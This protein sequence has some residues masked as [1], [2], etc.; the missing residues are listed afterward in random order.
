MVE[1]F[2]LLSYDQGFESSHREGENVKKVTD[3][4]CLKFWLL[5]QVQKTF[6]GRNLRIFIIS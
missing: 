5:G 6:Y 2:Y 1:D 3:Q 4:N